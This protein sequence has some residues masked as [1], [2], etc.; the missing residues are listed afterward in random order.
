MKLASEMPLLLSNTKTSSHLDGLEAA[1][2]YL[3]AS[4]E[5]KARVDESPEPVGHRTIKT[6][7]AEYKA[8]QEENAKTKQLAEEWRQ[9]YLSERKARHIN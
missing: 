6:W 5:V 9:Q 1:I 3:S 8:A 4:D 2:A 7:E